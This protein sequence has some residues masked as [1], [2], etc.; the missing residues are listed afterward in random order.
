MS[1]SVDAIA[2]N[3]KRSPR[4]FD[5]NIAGC[6]LDF[7]VIDRERVD[8]DALRLLGLFAI[9]DAAGPFQGQAL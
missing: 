2:R 9:V 7:A 4:S 1:S 3:R 6:F 5:G 8:A